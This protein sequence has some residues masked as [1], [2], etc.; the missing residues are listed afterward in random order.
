MAFFV[1][2]V[3]ASLGGLAALGMLLVFLAFLLSDDPPPSRSR[4]PATD[5]WLGRWNGPEGTFLQLEGGDGRY[6]VTIQD[7]DGPRRF[8]GTGVGDWIELERDGVRE[9]VRP[10]D[11]V[12][13]GMKWLADK[14][15][16]LTIRLGEGYCRD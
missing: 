4:A 3:I 2:L 13:T 7:L 12:G 10:T 6:V 16:C 9:S 5:R 11:G 8:Q 15:D 1:R 14:R